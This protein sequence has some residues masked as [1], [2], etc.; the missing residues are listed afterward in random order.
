[1]LGLEIQGLLPRRQEAIA[2]KIGEVVERDLR[3]VDDLVNQ[4]SD[5]EMQDKMV[6]LVSEKVRNR[7]E[8]AMP[9]LIPQNLA[10]VL[11][12]LVEGIRC[13]SRNLVPQ[14]TESRST[15]DREIEEDIA[16]KRILAFD[17]LLRAWL[18]S[19]IRELR[20]I[21]VLGSTR[22]L[23][24]LIQV[25]ILYYFRREDWYDK[26]Q[27][28]D[29]AIT[30]YPRGITALEIAKQIIGRLAR[31]AVAARFNG[32]LIDVGT[33]LNEDGHL[34][35][36]T[37]NDPEALEVYRHTTAHVMAQAVKRLYPDAA[38]AIGPAIEKGFYYDFDFP[39]AIGPEELA[40]IEQEM[41]R[42]IK[43]DYPLYAAKLSRAGHARC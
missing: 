3:S 14:V 32:R 7:L 36:L 43:E 33:A 9:R 10:R 26:N 42:I 1:M 6:K 21:E 11:A 24:G 5:P 28:K 22:F 31:E 4:F 2:N 23:I 39:E 18:G 27:L 19:G 40:A 37:A 38:L 20:F 16:R 13:E 34:E 41:T 25:A 15:F 8:E 29:G 35:I 30:E 17:I 12:D